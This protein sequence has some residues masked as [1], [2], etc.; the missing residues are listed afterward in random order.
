[1]GGAFRKRYGDGPLHLIAVVASFALAGYAFAEI[2]RNPGPVSFAVFFG[3]AVVAHDFVAFPL[4]TALDRIAGRLA[5]PVQPAGAMNYIRV[6]AVLSG[7]AFIVWFPL[8][9]GLARDEYEAAAAQAPPDYMA[10]WLGLTAALFALSGLV[11]A[12]NRRRSAP[13]RDLPTGPQGP[14][15]PR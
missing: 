4:Y 15:S 5:A 12:V 2:A 14:R 8:I 13:A 1:L 6:P 10:R 11:Y 7:L 9:I 3:G